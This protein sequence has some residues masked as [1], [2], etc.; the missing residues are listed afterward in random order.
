MSDYWS[1]TKLLYE[2]ILERPPLTE[3]HLKRPSPKFIFF[4]IINTLKI[5]EFPLGLFTEEEQTLEHFLENSENKIKFFKKIIGL[6]EMITKEKFFIVIK[7]ILKGKEC[8]KTNKFLQN[9][10][11]I[12]TS[13]ID[14]SKD[15]EK[16][17]LDNGYDISWLQAKN[18]SGQGKCIFWVNEQNDYY[19]E[20]KKNIKDNPNYRFLGKINTKYFINL[21]DLFDELR[22]ND[23]RIV[24][25]I[26]SESLYADYYYQLKHN[27]NNIKFIPITI[28]YTSY[29]IQQKI[30]NRI[31]LD[32]FKQEVYSTINESFYNFGGVSCDIHSCLNLISNFFMT[33]KKEFNPRQIPRSSFLGCMTFE[34][35]NSFNQLKLPMLYNEILNEET[36]V[37]DNEVQ[38]FKYL[39]LNRFGQKKIANLIHPLLYVKEMPHEMLA[40]FF[41]KTYTEQ[42]DFYPEM[43]NSLMKKNIKE[44]VAFIRIMYEGL[45][46]KSLSIT[47]DKI[48]YRG[49]SIGRNEFDAIR[50]KY[51]EYCDSDDKS[52]PAF[53]LYSRCFLSFSKVENVAQGFLGSN[54]NNTYAI[55]FVLKNN[56]NVLNKYSSNADIEFLSAFAYEKEV[57]FFPFSSFCVKNI[58]DIQVKNNMGMATK[59]YVKIELEY[60]GRYDIACE[61]FKKNINLKNELKEEFTDCF[62]E[63]NYSK[64]LRNANIIKSNKPNNNKD[65]FSI[66]NYIYN[67]LSE[68]IE[69]EYEIK[70]NQEPSG[71]NIDKYKEVFE[72]IEKVKI[73]PKDNKEINYEKRVNKNPKNKKEELNNKIFYINFYPIKYFTNIWKGNYNY[74]NQKHGKGQEYDIDGNLLFEGEYENDLK[75]VGKE[76]YTMNKK[77]KYEGNYRNGKW[78]NGKLFNLVN[79]YIYGIKS[80]NGIIKEFHENGCL[81]YDGEIKDGKKEG[82]GKIYDD[83]GSLIYDGI[84]I[85]GFKNGKGK[86][87]D[88]NRNLI[89]EG[90]FEN[91]KRKKIDLINKYN[92]LGELIYT[93]N[94]TEEKNILSIKDYKNHI[95]IKE[96]LWIMEKK[97][98][99]VK[100][101]KLKS[102]RSNSKKQFPK[103]ETEKKIFKILKFEEEDNDG[104]NGKVKEYDM[105]NN[106]IF[107]GEYKN[108]KR[109]NGTY[110]IKLREKVYYFIIEQG[111]FVQ[112]K[113]E[114]INPNDLIYE[115][116][117]QNGEGRIINIDGKVLF[118]GEFKNGLKYKGREYNE[119]KKLIFDGDYSKGGLIYNGYGKEF[120]NK[121]LVYEGTYKEGYKCDGNVKQYSIS[122]ILM[123]DGQ[124]KNGDR[125]EGKEYFNRGKKKFE[126][127]YLN[128]FYYKGKEYNYDSQLIFEGEYRNKKRWKG[129]GKEFNNKD[130]ELIYEGEYD[131]GKKVYGKIKIK[132]VVRTNR[133]N[134]LFEGYF[135]NGQKYKGI[136]YIKKDNTIFEGEYKNGLRFKGREY[137]FYK[138]DILKYEGE[139]KNGLKSKGKEYDYGRLIFE[140]T[141]IN[142]KRSNGKEYDP[143]KEIL[144]FEGNYENEKRKQGKI[145]N[146][147]GELTFNGEFI[148][149]KIWKGFAKNY[150][151]SNNSKYNDEFKN[152]KIW[153]GFA[154]N[155]IDNN[156][157]KYNGIFKN[158]RFSGKATEYNEKNCLIFEGEY[159][160]GK[161]K[162]GIY[163]FYDEEGK[164]ICINNYEEFNIILCQIFEYKIDKESGKTLIYYNKKDEDE[165][166]CEA[167]PYDEN[168]YEE[169]N[170]GTLIFKGE[171]RDGKKWNGEGK[172]YNTKDE[173]IF[174]GEFKNGKRWKGRGKEFNSNDELIFDGEYNNGKRWNGKGKEYDTKNRL[175]YDGKY[176]NGLNEKGLE[177]DYFSEEKKEENIINKEY[178]EYDELIFE[179]EMKEGIRLK[180]KE[181]KDGKIIYEGD[182]KDGLRFNGKGIEFNSKNMQIFEGEYKDGKKWK[183]EGNEYNNK[184]K[185]ILKRLYDNGDI[186]KETEYNSKGQ[187]IFDFE[188]KN[189]E[190]YKGI[191]YNELGEKIF[192]GEYKDN[193]RFSGKAKNNIFEYEYI[194]GKISSNNIA[195]YDYINHELFIGEYKDGEKYNGILRTYFDDINNILK[196]EVEV[197]EGNI[198]G[199]G[200]EYYGNQKLKYEG[201]YEN[202]K[203][204]GEGILYYRLSGYINYIGDF[205]DGKKEGQGKEFDNL[206]NLI[207]EG[208]YINDKRIS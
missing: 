12:A 112:K 16:Y 114:K 44:Y 74:K 129:R 172:E 81:A 139:Y 102:Y 116:D 196:R 55:L 90:I 162:N 106:L 189:N 30:K 111:I 120:I 34:Y 5:T 8:E 113:V 48:L 178:D 125:F 36:K 71:K 152:G 115:G 25:I 85:N 88:K 76:Y 13:G 24:Y 46:N 170:R 159:S 118:I 127:N 7:N 78:Y 198:K 52:L 18:D 35:I 192:E 163:Y 150:I 160:E 147:N 49:S 204:N 38:Y 108:G 164:L 199:K 107:E 177:Y 43:N 171:M 138:S 14:Y 20:L 201:Q 53:L 15:I 50:K 95:M 60:I 156:N 168:K 119:N 21:K 131:K 27:L 64:E 39:L 19:D 175:I 207:F 137:Y 194:N 157:S 47:E 72:V 83:T 91:G 41:T 161:K 182:Y 56:E 126:G 79:N 166:E 37:S 158:G 99:K 142:G 121:E 154:K 17:L 9:L 31:K 42:T 6:V 167:A 149:E 77:L 148:Y 188:F 197:K 82:N 134:I 89:F 1:E 110:I 173:I 200:K 128:K 124:L 145:Y 101:N 122:H 153:K 63:Q 186:I 151:Y 45:T 174:E 191:E 206:G 80:G 140:G 195:V 70:V 69:K 146:T 54:N 57:L 105:N 183:G 109:Y 2:N 117:C 205:K 141:Y 59:E 190:R 75:I 84:V 179:G 32:F 143:E 73:I 103:E 86:E 58:E 123:F 133:H 26:I 93:K 130:K 97:D 144:I 40:K 33:M 193:I 22:N 176:I 184:E 29:S 61:K 136:E 87:Y 92:E 203:K 132:K 208:Q 68:K 202:G 51:K 181:Y 62:N 155:Y 66:K 3:K 135:K 11:K 185:L 98:E 165:V 23:F 180:G 187:I 65:A 169:K 100:L 28:I 67:R 4:L 96:G 104:K 94:E 10:Y